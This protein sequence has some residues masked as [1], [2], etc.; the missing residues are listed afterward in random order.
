MS[1][2]DTISRLQ[3]AFP[4]LDVQSVE[5]AK[6]P[7]LVIPVGELPRVAAWLR[8]KAGY[9]YLS[10]VTGVD[11]G[12]RFEVIYHLYSIERGG[13]PLVLK[14]TGPWDKAEVPSVVGIWPAAQFQEREVYDLLGVFFPGHPDLRRI[15]LWDGFP[16]HPLRKTYQNRTMPHA[17]VL[18]TMTGEE[19]PHAEN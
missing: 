11:R 16:G 2:H 12:E 8:D 3:A 15:F 13:G 9:N 7:T 5:G 14:V 19:V 4:G 17:E 18:P 10:N 6:D 1:E